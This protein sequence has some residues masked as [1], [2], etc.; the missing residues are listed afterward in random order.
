M[1]L[2]P[3]SAYGNL[4]YAPRNTSGDSIELDFS[5]DIIWN[6][7]MMSPTGNNLKEGEIEEMYL[8]LGYEWDWSDS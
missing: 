4:H 3:V 7:Q 2:T 6:L 8:I 5:S 1:I